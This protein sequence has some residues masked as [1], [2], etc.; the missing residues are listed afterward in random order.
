[1]ETLKSQ[2]LAIIDQYKALS[3]AEK[4]TVR[5]QLEREG[6]MSMASMY[7]KMRHGSFSVLEA[8]YMVQ[9]FKEIRDA[10]AN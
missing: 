2:N 9:L 1:M 6:I 8:K 5:H 4:L 7:Y 3:D 10:R